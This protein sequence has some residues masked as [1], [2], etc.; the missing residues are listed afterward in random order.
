M[1]E[2]QDTTIFGGRNYSR[3]HSRMASLKKN[4]KDVLGIRKWMKVR[5]TLRLEKQENFFSM[6]NKQKHL[7]LNNCQP[8]ARSPHVFHE[9]S[10]NLDSNF[11]HCSH[12]QSLNSSGTIYWGYVAFSDTHVGKSDHHSRSPIE[13]LH[14]CIPQDQWPKV[15]VVTVC[16]LSVFRHLLTCLLLGPWHTKFLW[17]NQGV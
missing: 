17:A 8:L 10:C 2:P 1:V 16:F 3:T 7:T 12:E 6:R 9:S 13:F 4:G 14:S 15:A 11:S 5:Q